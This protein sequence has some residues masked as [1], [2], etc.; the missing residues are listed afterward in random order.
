MKSDKKKSIENLKDQKVDASKVSGGKREVPIEF[1]EGRA[2]D[3]TSGRTEPK[4]KIKFT[5]RPRPK[6]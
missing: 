4:A 3:E 2:D 6:F 5:L 1:I